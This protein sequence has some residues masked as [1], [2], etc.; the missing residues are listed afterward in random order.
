MNAIHMSTARRMLMAPEPVCIKCWTKSGGILE[1][2]KAIPLK[3]NFYE[4]TRQFKILSS[5]EIRTLRVNL[6]FELNGLPVFL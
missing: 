4:G 6:I 5:R 1:L 3:Y 2:S